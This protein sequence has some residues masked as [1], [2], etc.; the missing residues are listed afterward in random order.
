VARTAAEGPR[1]RRRVRVELG[2]WLLW[3]V[4]GLTIAGGVLRFT[5]L[6]ESYWYDEAVTVRLARSSFVSMI[7]AL[8]GSESTPPLYY[9]IAWVWARIFGT[10]EVALRSLSALFG[11][12]AIPVAAAAGRTFASGAAGA[13]VG[14]LAAASPFLIWY[15]Q[16]ARA[17]ALYVLLSASSLLLFARAR[18]SPSAPRIW[19]WAGASAL[20]VWTEYFAGFLV[21]AEAAFLLADRRSRHFSR[22]PMLALAAAIALLLPLVYKQ[23]RNGHNS[24]IGQESPRA[25]AEDALRWFF[26]LPSHLWWVAATLAVLALVS[27]GLARAKG[28]RAALV[29]LTLAAACILLPLALRAVG[30]DY[31]LA[32]NV[33]DAWVPLAIAFATVIVCQAGRAWYTRSALLG[34]AL[35][36]VA[37]LAMRS[38]TIVTDPSKRADWRGL[39]TCLGRPDAERAFVISPAYN[40]VVL[41]L[42]RP[43]VRPPRPTDHGVTE[44]D[45]IGNPGALPIFRRFH[46]DGRMCTKAIAVRRSRATAPVRIP[47]PTDQA[48]ILVDAA[49][50]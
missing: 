11:T 49:T 26:G 45:I 20:A 16:E 3:L 1:V 4:V 7:R 41:K 39:A 47:R 42:Y 34:L 43:N 35:A 29:P 6:G 36:A 40:D 25:R 19:L 22:R 31:W 2:D 21:V 13:L 5:K 15:S 14:A 17:Y 30:K 50:P 38:T 12:A 18:R 37:L 24:W 28:R 32:R 33:I 9:A 8:P 10:N 48:S 44:I 46:P 23:A 27:A